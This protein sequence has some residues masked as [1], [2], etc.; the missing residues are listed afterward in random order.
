ML[1]LN[2]RSIFHD[3]SD[4]SYDYDD[5]NSDKTRAF[6]RLYAP[7]RRTGTFLK[8]KKLFN[9]YFEGIS[10]LRTGTFLEV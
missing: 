7:V 1:Q 10:Y 2:H 9:V 5:N 4:E 8:R 3:D 6:L